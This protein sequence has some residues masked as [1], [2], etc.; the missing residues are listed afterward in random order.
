MSETTKPIVV[1]ENAG[2][3]DLLT[4]A[5]R[6]AV[7]IATSIPILLQLLGSRNIV[8]IMTYFRGD[9]GSTLMAAVIGLGTL[10]YGLFKTRKRGA[11]IA[12]VALDSRVPDRVAT[13][14]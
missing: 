8:E 4:A 10:A 7:V 11:Q 6:Y 5:G 1:S 14:K 9:A 2:I 13:T 12:T 3:I